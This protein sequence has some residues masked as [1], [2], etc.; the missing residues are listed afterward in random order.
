MFRQIA[1]AF[2]L[3]VSASEMFARTRKIRRIREVRVLF[4]VF[5]CVFFVKLSFVKTCEMRAFRK[6]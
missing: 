3:F 5:F 6:M 1:F 2:L 4:D